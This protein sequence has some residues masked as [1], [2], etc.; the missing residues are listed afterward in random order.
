VGRQNRAASRIRLRL[1]GDG[2]TKIFASYGRFFDRVKFALPR[3]LF[4]GDIFLKITSRLFPG[5]T[6]TG[7]NI[8]NIVGGFT[9]QRLPL[10][11]VYRSG[12]EAGVK[13]TC[14]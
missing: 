7:F 12:H 2:K 5:D 3:G 13:E 10:D 6:S 8:S 1:S 4:G 9:D 11:R 14:G